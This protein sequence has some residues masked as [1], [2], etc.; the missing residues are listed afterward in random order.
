MTVVGKGNAQRNGMVLWDEVSR[1]VAGEFE[2]V[3]V[4]WCLVDAM[5]ARM[6]LRPETVDTVVASNLVSVVFCVLVWGFG[7]M[8]WVGEKG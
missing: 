7:S 1:E 3:E 2:D 5:A 8:K 4:D 6:V